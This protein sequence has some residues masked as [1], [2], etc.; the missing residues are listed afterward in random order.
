[1]H[2]LVSGFP[3]LPAA[4]TAITIALWAFSR[5]PEYLTALLFFGGAMALAAAPREVVFSGFASA[6][7]WL[8]LS[9]YVLGLA[10]KYTGLADRM[11]GLL[12][13]RLAGGYLTVTAGVVTLTYLLAFVMPS[14]MGRIAL[15][16]P[17]VL[18]YA[19]RIGLA[20]G[21]RGRIGLA[22]AVGFGTFQLSTSVLPANVPNLVMAGSIEGSYGLQLGY[23]PYLWLH[24]P[25]LGILK[26]VLLTCCIAWMFR[27]TPRRAEQAAAA[28]PLSAAEKRLGWLLAL[29]LL[30]WVTDSVHGVSPAW[31]G[32][33][34]A[35]V[36][37]LPKV[38]FV[39]GD[40]FGKEVNFRTAIYVAGI[41][42]LAAMVADSGL[43]GII[44][45][46]LLAWLPLS[47]D[48]PMRSFFSLVGLSAL[49][50]FV[51][52]ANGVPAL[53]TPLAETLAQASGFSLMAVLMAQVAGYA[54]VVMPYQ[55]S[56]IVVAMGM[57]QVPARSGLALSLVTAL[58]SFALL[59]PLDYLWF[60]LLGMLGS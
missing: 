43:G 49:L 12:S 7:F 13:R 15:L 5:L 45:K 42:G 4:L 57:G 52:T 27:D 32:L 60:R 21:S 28:A 14:N 29:T 22:L 9:G 23:L 10:L 36:C 2:A 16:M 30:G 1:M 34:S 26:G 56:P 19:D 59:V 44:G 3:I 50:N 55:A 39:S 41:L 31:I 20:P 33:L 37:L 11:A 24:A 48:A 8:V 35:C 25:V 38:G 17:I 40:Q 18:A 58:L 54:T 51:V 6:A 46:A 47:P 53:Y